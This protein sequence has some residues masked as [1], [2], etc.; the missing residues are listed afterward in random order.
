MFV[1][2]SLQSRL[3]AIFS[4][5]VFL[6]KISHLNNQI[7]TSLGRF[8]INEPT[9]YKLTQGADPVPKRKVEGMAEGEGMRE[10][11]GMRPGQWGAN[12]H[13]FL[14]FSSCSAA[15]NKHISPLIQYWLFCLSNIICPHWRCRVWLLVYPF[16][17]LPQLLWMAPCDFLTTRSSF[18]LC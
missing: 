8:W 14:L 18:W 3:I 15:N 13:Y 6:S 9:K 12:S 4:N 11:A 17:F 7:W 1:L 10:G 16:L 5:F 2:V